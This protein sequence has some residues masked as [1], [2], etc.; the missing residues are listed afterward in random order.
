MALNQ[1]TRE[2]ILKKSKENLLM[3]RYDKEDKLY[4]R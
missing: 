3:Q 1:T 2:Y 4:V